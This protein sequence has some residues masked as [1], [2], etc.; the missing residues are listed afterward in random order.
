MM[1]NINL[2]YFSP[3]GTTKKI[4]ASIGKGINTEKITLIDL[5]FPDKQYR[6]TPEDGLFLFAVPVYGGRIPVVAASRLRKLKG[7]N[8]PCIL[9]VVYG[10]R[11]FDDAL[12][13]LK[14]LVIGQG[15]IPFTAAAFVAEHSFSTEHYPIAV[16]RPDKDDLEKA[17]AF[18]K[19]IRNVIK[20][21]N[22]VEKVVDVPGNYPYKALSGK[23]NIFPITIESKCT[24]CGVC[25]SLC[26]TGSIRMNSFPETNSSTCILCCA[27]IKGCPNNARINDNILF[28]Q[29]QEWLI[30]NCSTRKEPEIFSIYK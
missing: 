5:T 3:T 28:I 6:N 20:N 10:N 13:E 17:F 27:C 12:L 15:F 1:N 19:E 25:V 2:V 8:S 26:P 11:D 4:A 7:N 23:T 14:D 9:I 22:I 16:R 18:G 21:R 30:K 29:K 24:K